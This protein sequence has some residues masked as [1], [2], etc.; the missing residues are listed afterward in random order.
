M[1]SGADDRVDPAGPAL[2][3]ALQEACG[4]D[5][6]ME[7]ATS[8]TLNGHKWLHNLGSSLCA[9]RSL[10]ELDLSRCALT[11]L[12]GL[13]GLCNLEQ[14]NLYYNSLSDLSEVDRLS[15]LPRLAVLDLRLNPLTRAGPR[16]RL[17]VLRAVPSLRMLDERGVSG[18]ERQRATSFGPAARRAAEPLEDDAALATLSTNAAVAMECSDAMAGC[19]STS[20][21]AA[22]SYA[23]ASE[24]APSAPADAPLGHDAARPP[25]AGGVGGGG[26]GGGGVGGGMGGGC[27]G[28]GGVGRGGV[29]GGCVGGVGVG[30]AGGGEVRPATSE[31]S[32]EGEVVGR[33][34]EALEAGAQHSAADDL[35]DV[36]DDKNTDD[37][38][39]LAGAKGAAL[40]D[41]VWDAVGGSASDLCED[42]GLPAGGEGGG[43]DGGG[44]EGGGGER[45]GGEG[46]GG[47]GGGG[48]GGAGE[49]GGEGGGGD[50]GGGDR[51]GGER[52]VQQEALDAGSIAGAS[53]LD[54][55]AS[56]LDLDSSEAEA[57]S[58]TM[59]A[60]PTCVPLAAAPSEACDDAPI[61]AASPCCES[62][63]MA[64]H[65]SATCSD[66][67]ASGS[68]EASG[69]NTVDSSPRMARLPTSS[70]ASELAPIA[71]SDS[72]RPVLLPSRSTQLRST[73]HGAPPRTNTGG[74]ERRAEA[75][76]PMGGSL[77][78]QSRLQKD[79]GGGLT[80][81]SSLALAEARWVEEQ[82]GLDTELRW[83]RLQK[84]RSPLS[85][86]CVSLCRP[87]QAAGGWR[88]VCYGA[89]TSE[90]EKMV[91]RGEAS[92]LAVRL[93]AY[94]LNTRTEEHNTLFHSYLAYF[95]NTFT[96]NM[97][98]SYVIYRIKQSE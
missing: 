74:G 65:P 82:R 60:R 53:G 71:A 5:L 55:G 49:G 40:I 52:A 3:L 76:I 87:V 81:A 79:T 67:V 95:V 21:C 12:E 14:L 9:A 64:A 15:L 44:G 90:R 96:L 35:H 68:A 42:V 17:C 61:C 59:E 4:G 66:N 56:D 93:R 7:E 24:P 33:A 1:A 19:A 36:A 47:K 80:M 22:S 48:D 45:G 29:V 88:A 63:E 27:V 57:A 26:V 86:L 28:G 94:M 84:V 70:P 73:E 30:G 51:G 38:L 58:P 37:G 69:V 77:P 83:L 91:E 23:S 31:E 46:G 8:L 32:L 10:R 6:P 13:Q 25:A 16:Y 72:G 34:D 98:A 39:A 2:E 75:G 41:S 89:P 20:S 62:L 92:S 18:L 85:L 78:R 11:S 43:G 50:G 54:M 97:Y